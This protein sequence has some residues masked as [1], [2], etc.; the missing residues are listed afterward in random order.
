MREPEQSVV[1][2]EDPAQ[3]E[4]FDHA[5]HRQRLREYFLNHGMDEMRDYE[6]LELF[7]FYSIPRQDTRPIARRLLNKFGS[8]SAVLDA[9]IGEIMTVGGI[10]RNSA[11]LLKMLPDVARMY[12]LDKKENKVRLETTD[13]IRSYL[14]DFFIGKRVECF[15]ILC[16]DRSCKLLR[17]T[18]LGE[19]EEY[20]VAV[21]INKVSL[22][23]AESAA[24]LVVIAH[25]HPF[26][27]AL[28]SQQDV[29]L[30]KNIADL[31]RAM[32]VSLIDH[33]IFSADDVFSMANSKKFYKLFFN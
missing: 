22:E 26:G 7:L 25:N 19:G 13:A 16:M 1:L 18:K 17:C 10:G 4:L 15:Y 6:I 23:I 30:T 29:T 14:A 32:G 5:G 33:L 8:L 31:A 9:N 2:P 28:P 27:M 24:S 11:C 3:T 20:N 12:M 21:S